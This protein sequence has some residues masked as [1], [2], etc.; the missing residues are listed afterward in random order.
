MPTPKRIDWYDPDAERRARIDGAWFVAEQYSEQLKILRA[1]IHKW[2]RL[3]FVIDSR[4][5]QLPRRPADENILRMVA[6][7]LEDRAEIV[8]KMRRTIA[9]AVHLEE[10]LP[11]KGAA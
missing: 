8:R 4:W 5:G 7:M 9:Y 2:W 1:M 11:I 3:A 6:F 10:V